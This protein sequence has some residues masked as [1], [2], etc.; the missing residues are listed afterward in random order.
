ME[1]YAKI[2]ETLET[3]VKYL[4]KE[5]DDAVNAKM[6]SDNELIEVRKRY[7]T[8]LGVDSLPS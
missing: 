3:K 4:Q 8:I 2:L 5:R 6:H 7:I 1:N